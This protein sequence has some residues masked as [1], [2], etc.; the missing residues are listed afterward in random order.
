MASK[1]DCQIDKKTMKIKLVGTTI[2]L[3]HQGASLRV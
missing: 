1:I 3:G 2:N